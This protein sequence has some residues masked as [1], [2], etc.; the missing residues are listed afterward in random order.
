MTTIHEGDWEIDTTF[1]GFY[2]LKNATFHKDIF[3][4]SNTDPGHY[5]LQFIVNDMEGQQTVLEEEFEI[6]MPDDTVSPISKVISEPYSKVAFSNC[7]K[8]IFPTPACYYKAMVNKSVGSILKNQHLID[9]KVYSFISVIK[10]IG[11]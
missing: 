1:S 6:R 10:I 9:D 3:I 2:G 8:F 11:T 7:K 5:H 4:P